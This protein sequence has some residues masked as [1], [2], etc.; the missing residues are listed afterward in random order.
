MN[1]SKTKLYFARFKR[2]VPSPFMAVAASGA[3]SSWGFV[4]FGCVFY[5]FFSFFFCRFYRFLSWFSSHFFGRLLL[6]RFFSFFLSLLLSPGRFLRLSLP[7]SPSL[8]LLLSPMRSPC[9]SLTWSPSRSFSR[10]LLLLFFGFSYFSYAL[11]SF[12]R[13]LSFCLFLFLVFFFLFFSSFSL[14]LVVF[15]RLSSDWPSPLPSLA[16]HPLSS[17]VSATGAS[18]PTVSV[19]SGV[20]SSALGGG[21][22]G[23]SS[24]GVLSVAPV[25]EDSVSVSG[26]LT[27]TVSDDPTLKS[28]SQSQGF[29]KQVVHFIS[30]L[31][32]KNSAI[33]C[34][35]YL[36]STGLF[37]FWRK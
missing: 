11:S 27:L 5:S 13:C 31:W 10:S 28:C 6:Y 32:M 3:R 29:F 23:S 35:F 20:A 2:S 19:V 34:L 24:R 9:W 36:V 26:P 18:V 14:P 33:L 25:P 21:S 30:V 37:L 1:Y 4:C 17:S 7:W 8:S 15:L 16:S 12:W 22:D